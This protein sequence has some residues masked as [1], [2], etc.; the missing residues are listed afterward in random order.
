M[1]RR[2]KRRSAVVAGVLA[3][4]GLL[5]PGVAQAEPGV[6]PEWNP[7]G[8]V[9]GFAP[10]AAIDEFAGCPALDEYPLIHPDLLDGNG[11]PVLDENGDP[12]PDTAAAPIGRIAPDFCVR[13]TAYNGE[14]KLGNTVVSVDPI[15]LIFGFNLGG[16]VQ[17]PQGGGGVE[18][19][20]ISGGILGIPELDPL[21]DLSLGLLSLSATPRLGEPTPGNSNDPFVPDPDCTGFSCMDPAALNF[22]LWLAT[23]GDEGGGYPVELSL[24]LS[25]QLNNTLFGP[26][27]A[28]DEFAINLTSGTTTPPAGVAPMTGDPVGESRKTIYEPFPVGTDFVS[29]AEKTPI[30]SRI[31]ARLVDNTF[32]VPNATQCDFLVGGLLNQPFGLFDS[33]IGSQ[34]GLPSPAGRNHAAF[35]V[36]AD[37]VT[38]GSNFFYGV[39]VAPK[40][41]TTPFFPGLYPRAG[42]LDFGTVA[43]GSSATRTLT[44]TGSG[45]LPTAESPFS[46]ATTSD[47]QFAITANTCE[48]AVLDRGESCTIDVTFTP[49]A[50]G[51][52]GTGF[53]DPAA[54]LVSYWEPDFTKAFL[55]NATIV[56][57]AV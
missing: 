30:G 16:H 37:L 57:V 3:A 56:A 24:P 23:T 40:G 20:K 10:Q 9:P 25:I 44:L 51:A 36:A 17:F 55:S 52:F 13:L 2:F 48:G 38:Y 47:S 4:T 11:D 15:S 7:G 8:T 35:D 6:F 27:C 1:I 5:A 49:T 12:V 14:L 53:A 21:W 31:G 32:A 39:D 28:I 54:G 41:D 34:V 22:G 45:A 46:T 19:V 43:V 42:F 26:N 50:P 29:D 18:P 33:L